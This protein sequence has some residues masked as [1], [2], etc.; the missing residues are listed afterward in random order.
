MTFVARYNGRC[1]GCGTR[2]RVGDEVDYIGS[3]VVH[4]GCRVAYADW[5][6]T[7]PD[8]DLEPQPVVTGRR[9]HQK[10]CGECN[11]I[12]AGECW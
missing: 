2:I 9:N 7:E 6:A 5:Q 1:S 3:R 12:H 10:L 8:D 4:E 11:T